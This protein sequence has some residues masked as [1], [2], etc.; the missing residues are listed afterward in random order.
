MESLLIKIEEGKTLIFFFL[1]LLRYLFFPSDGVH[2]RA[3]GD[4]Y[5]DEDFLYVKV[6][7]EIVN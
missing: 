2:P 5:F 7:G 4:E 6:L 3:I 1:L